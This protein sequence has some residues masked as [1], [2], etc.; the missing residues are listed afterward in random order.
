MLIS[1]LMI[2]H[3]AVLEGFHSIS[4]GQPLFVKHGIVHQDMAPRDRFSVKSSSY[5]YEILYSIR[6]DTIIRV[7][8]LHDG[9]S[10]TNAP[11]SAIVRGINLAALIM[12]RYKLNQPLSWPGPFVAN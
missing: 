4:T 10:H 12:I 6:N 11:D 1:P 7:S 9:N 3:L 2:G 8:Y 5:R